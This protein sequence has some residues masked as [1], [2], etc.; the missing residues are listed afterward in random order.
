MEIVLNEKEYRT[1]LELMEMAD[2]VLHAHA[3]DDPPETLKYRQFAQKIYASAKACGNGDLVHYDQNT[4]QFYP[5]EALEESDAV[6]DRI[7]A[8]ENACFWDELIQRLVER[9]LIQ[10]E[11]EAAFEQM[12]T[13]ERIDRAAPIEK[14]YETVFQ[15]SGIDRLVIAKEKSAD[16]DKKRRESN[17][18]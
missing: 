10:S 4:Q 5:S 6:L 15:E 11:A 1:L 3:E 9:D 18:L 2:W 17:G 13:P 7:A 16:P 12:A 14:M 8:F